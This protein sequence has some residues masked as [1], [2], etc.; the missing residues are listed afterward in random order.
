MVYGITDWEDGR[1]ELVAWMQDWV[2]MEDLGDFREDYDF[3]LQDYGDGYY[4]VE[5]SSGQWVHDMFEQ[6]AREY[7]VE[8]DW[9]T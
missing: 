6:L 4:E 1:N 2:E 5:T 3:D 9:L 7:P 8:V